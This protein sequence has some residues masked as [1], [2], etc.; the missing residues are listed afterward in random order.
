MYFCRSKFV[1]SFQLNVGG[2]F[3]K[4]KR[5]SLSGTSSNSPIV[6]DA[7]KF[8]LLTRDLAALTAVLIPFCVIAH[9]FWHTPPKI[10]IVHVLMLVGLFLLICVSAQNY[11][12]RFVANVLVETIEKEKENGTSMEKFK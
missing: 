9:L 11:G 10:I 2:L 6:Y 12:K 5:K 4:I 1:N 3:G 7:Q 8:F